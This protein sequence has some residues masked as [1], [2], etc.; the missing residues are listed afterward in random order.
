MDAQRWPC[1]L[2][3]PLLPVISVAPP[4]GL[5]LSLH[6]LPGSLHGESL[7]SE[8]VMAMGYPRPFQKSIKAQY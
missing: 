6:K 1:A 5:G 7:K 4:S 2:G 8:S 3:Q